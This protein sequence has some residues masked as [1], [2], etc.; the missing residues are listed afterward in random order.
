MKR[1]AFTMLELVFVIIVIGI[2]A[3]L[4]MPS[5][6]SNSLQKAAEQ[7][8][9]HIQY[10][11]HLAMIDDKFDPNDQLWFR[12]NWQIEFTSTASNV[13]YKIY[14]DTDH[15]GNSDSVTHK[16]VATDPLSGDSLDGNSDVTDLKKRFAIT[17]VAFSSSC[18]GRNNNGGGLPTGGTGKELSFDSLGR[19]YIYITSATPLASN[20]YAYLLTSDCNITLVH[21]SEGNA[22]I[23]V[24]P[25]SG[26]VS[27]VY[28]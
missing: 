9:E 13:W 8:A 5:F 17:S 18:S 2:L 28:N 7:V 25:E 19:P 26:Y 24:R 16:E 6:T 11:Q 10:T 4:A 14:C 22:T 27:V 20:I 15:N 12:E 1:F 21:E 23:I 3:V